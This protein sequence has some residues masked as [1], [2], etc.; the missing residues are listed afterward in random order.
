MIVLVLGVAGGLGQSRQGRLALGMQ[1]QLLAKL[2]GCKQMWGTSFLY[3]RDGP[4]P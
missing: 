1:A 3:Q 2:A 4:T